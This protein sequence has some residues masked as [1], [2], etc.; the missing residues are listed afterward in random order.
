MGTMRSFLSI[1][2]AQTNASGSVYCEVGFRIGISS[3]IAL[4]IPKTIVYSW[5][6]GL[7][8]SYVGFGFLKARFGSRFT[9]TTG[10]SNETLPR[11]HEVLGNRLCNVVF[12][13]GDHTTSMIE[14]DF[15]NFAKVS[16]PNAKFVFDDCWPGNRIHTLVMELVH[17]GQYRLSTLH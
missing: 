9:L 3:A 8:P 6:L 12:I 7:P 4:C 10:S 5:D 13:D 14:T 2:K 1:I 17:E 11:A 15:N 16:A